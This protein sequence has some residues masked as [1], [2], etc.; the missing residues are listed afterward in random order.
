[1][2][3]VMLVFLLVSSLL[4]VFG[5]SSD[6]EPVIEN[7]LPDEVNDLDEVEIIFDPDD[8]FDD[9]D[10]LLDDDFDDFLDEEFFDHIIS[11]DTEFSDGVLFYELEV[12]KPTPCHEIV[13]VEELRNDVLVITL[14]FVSTAEIC[15]QVITPE[16]ISGEFSVDFEPNVLVFLE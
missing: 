2:K 14:S 16:N 10:D 13:I 7:G 9:L 6:D 4:F 8:D 1:M 12:L 3:K 15:A 11:V 5:C